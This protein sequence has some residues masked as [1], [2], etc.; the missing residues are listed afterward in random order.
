MKKIFLFFLLS[1]FNKAIAQNVAINNTGNTADASALLDISSGNKGLLMPRVNLQSFTDATTIALPATGLLLYNTNA[2]LGT[3]FYYNSNTAASPSWTKLVTG[4]SDWKLGGNAIAATDFIGTTN[5]LPLVFKVYGSKSGIIDFA[6]NSTA[7]GYSSLKSNTTGTGN[8]SLGA[9]SL[10]ANTIG[11]N[12]TA[13][14]NYTLQSNLSG[15]SNTALGNYALYSNIT[16][17]GN[18]AAG[19]HAL[20]SNIDGNSNLALGVNSLTNNVSGAY[21]IALG[22]GAMYNNTASYQNIAIGLSAL[23]KNKSGNNNI[24]HGTNALYQD[25]SGANNIAS[26]YNALYNNL[27]GDNN[28]AIGLSTLYANKYSDDN[29]AIGQGALNANTMPAS[30]AIGTLALNKN[31]VGEN[32]MAVGYNA[33]KENTNGD[34]NTAIGFQALMANT[35]GYNNTAIGYQALKVNVGLHYNNTA[36]GY[37][38]LKAAIANGNTAVGA[39]SLGNATAGAD[40]TAIGEDALG[41]ITTGSRNT[42]VGN[43]ATSTGNHY[44]TTAIGYGTVVTA[45]QQV[46]LGNSSVTSIGGFAPWT[47]LS[48]KRFKKNIEG[49][50]PG[51]DFILKLKP[52]TYNYDIKKLDAFTGTDSLLKSKNDATQ[53][54]LHNQSVDKKEAIRYTGFIAQDVEQSAKEIN[55]DFS[56]VIKPQNEKD[57]YSLAYSEFVVPLVKAVQEQQQMIEELKKEIDLLKSNGKQVGKL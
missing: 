14:G 19:N 50:V 57:H 46:R 9:S 4:S 54:K 33:L 41:G 5:N 44:N 48:D 11:S 3:G 47:D 56:G 55:Y 28:I 31:T 12:N 40:N 45:D 32:N 21:N 8:S 2:I 15:N 36:L 49:N 37:N 24:A 22:D 23:Y 26:G 30:I 6:T 51:L 7:F 38:A 25:T 20:F 35:T 52:V 42:A 34:N 1:I 16:G 17:N 53:L 10:T 18:V 29:I 27:S 39:S 13:F 43:A